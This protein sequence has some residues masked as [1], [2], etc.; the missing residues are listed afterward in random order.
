MCHLVQYIFRLFEEAGEVDPK[1]PDRTSTRK[2]S[3]NEEWIIVGLILDNPGLYLGE[4]C[5]NIADVTGT[6]ISSPT[7]SYSPQAWLS[8]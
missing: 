6:W 3:S 1:H 4:I 8:P 2:L 7:V 5:Q